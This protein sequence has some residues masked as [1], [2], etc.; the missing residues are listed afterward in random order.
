MCRRRNAAALLSAVSAAILFLSL[1]LFGCWSSVIS[2]LLGERFWIIFEINTSASVYYCQCKLKSKKN[3]VGLGTR[4]LIYYVLA[5]STTMYYAPGRGKCFESHDI[6]Q[7]LWSLRPADEASFERWV[8]SSSE[9]IA[10]PGL[11]LPWIP[12][13]NSMSLT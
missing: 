8:C 10:L 4:L 9:L 12:I 13:Y 5:L 11:W 3:R 2:L 1:A 6:L 7:C